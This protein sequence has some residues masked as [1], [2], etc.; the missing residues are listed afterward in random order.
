MRVFYYKEVT[1]R[2]LESLELKGGDGGACKVLGWLLRDVMVMQGR[3]P[4]WYK[5]KKANKQGRMAAN[6]SSGFDDHFSADTPFDMGYENEIGGG[7]DQRLV[8]AVCQEMMKMFKGK[9]GD[10]SV[11]RDHASTSHA[12]ILSCC[13]ASFALFCHPHMNIKE[14]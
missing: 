6:V 7:V 12:C 3:Y 11:S 13:T 5:G 8:A 10:N 1:K 4:D 14:D 2:C 9:G